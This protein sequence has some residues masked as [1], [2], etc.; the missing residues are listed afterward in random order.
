MHKS[1]HF[2]RLSATAAH[3]P[4]GRNCCTVIYR[5]LWTNSSDPV[6][7]Y[8]APMFD[9]SNCRTCG[10]LAWES[11]Q[12]TFESVPVD[13]RGIL[14]LAVCHH[15]TPERRPRNRPRVEMSNVGRG[16]EGGG[17]FHFLCLITAVRRKAKGPKCGQ[18]SERL[19]IMY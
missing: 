16:C 14:C 17:G 4:G 18:P 19:K 8:A 6:W 12:S 3:Q 9:V 5:A 2:F 10:V 15:A 11:W 1:S 7:R 13:L